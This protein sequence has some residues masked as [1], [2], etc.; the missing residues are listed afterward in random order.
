MLRMKLAMPTMADEPMCVLFIGTPRCC[1]RHTTRQATIPLHAS[2][3]RRPFQTCKLATASIV[4]FTD[5]SV[6][7]R[8]AK[9]PS[10]FSRFEM[11]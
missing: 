3:K 2:A 11:K 1:A 4:D 5:E 9:P 7:G 8:L 10:A 6:P